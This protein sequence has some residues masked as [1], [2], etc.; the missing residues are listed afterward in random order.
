[1]LVL[2]TRERKIEIDK[3]SV[4]ELWICASEFGIDR[5]SMTGSGKNGRILKADLIKYIKLNIPY[6]SL[7]P[8][9]QYSPHRVC[10]ESYGIPQ[11]LYMELWLDN[12]WPF[13]SFK[14]VSSYKEYENYETRRSDGIVRK[15]SYDNYFDMWGSGSEG[16]GIGSEN[17]LLNLR[18]AVMYLE[19]R[20]LYVKLKYALQ[21][22]LLIDVIKYMVYC[23]A[24]TGMI[25]NITVR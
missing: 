9:Y 3:M 4:G 20:A 14:K 10:I 5:S 7:K 22:Y 2:Y 8:N 23:E 1:M 16:L 11:K 12:I 25:N 17:G 24:P 21:P 15:L 13:A 6:N 18:K 19:A